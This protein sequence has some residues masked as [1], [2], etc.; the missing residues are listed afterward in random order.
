[1]HPLDNA[2][3]NALQTRQSALGK[4]QG[5]ARKFLPEINVLA[6][7]SEHSEAA[8]ADLASLLQAREPAALFLESASVPF[9]GLK[10]I[11]LSGVS[12]ML[13]AGGAV[14]EQA[15]PADIVRLGPADVPEM[16]ELT[17]LTEPGPFAERTREM[18]EYFGIR[19]DGKLVAMA[20]ERLK[21]PG[22]TEVSAVC[23][24]PDYLGRGY[25][26][27]LMGMVMR[28]IQQRE[29]TPFLH[30]RPENARA[31]S[32]YNLLGFKMRNTRHLVVVG[33]A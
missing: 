20:G 2:I 23:T 17:R 12:Q 26:R 5:L 4:A 33:K 24:H 25:A 30:V 28:V 19:Q 14:E 32:L 6:G 22:F 15:I 7:V 16:L 27:S 21:L 29:E 13:Y 10:T 18:G 31:I 1:M 9:A 11:H 8:F 3:W